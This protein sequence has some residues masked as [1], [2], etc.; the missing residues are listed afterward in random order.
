M[1]Y[2]L[3]FVTVCFGCKALKVLTVESV[4]LPC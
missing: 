4:P 1:A 2:L 3:L